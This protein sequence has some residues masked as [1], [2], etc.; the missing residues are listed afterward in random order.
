MGAY[1]I[2]HVRMRE[3]VTNCEGLAQLR[4]TVEE[5][6]GRWHAS[7]DERAL[8]GA[9]RNSQVLVE[10]RT[11]TEAQRWYD[12]SEYHDIARQYVENSIDLALVDGI[13]P[14]F[15]MAGFAQDPPS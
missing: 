5:Y 15:T 10:F 2:N 7:P 4:R 3:C 14:D 9:R 12:S 11:M 1:L 13:G 6:G 8:E